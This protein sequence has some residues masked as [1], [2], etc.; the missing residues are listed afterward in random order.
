LLRD[1]R[2]IFRRF[3]PGDRQFRRNF[4][5]PCLCN[6]QRRLQGGVFSGKLSVSGVHEKK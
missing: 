3:G 2:H 1:Q 6:G 5:G 4:E